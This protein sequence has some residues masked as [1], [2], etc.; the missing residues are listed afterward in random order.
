MKDKQRE[1]EE[2]SLTNSEIRKNAHSVLFQNGNILKLIGGVLICILTLIL[3]LIAGRAVIYGFTG[4]FYY[5]YNDSL[6]YIQTTLFCT[7]LYYCVELLTICFVTVPTWTALNRL[8]ADIVSGKNVTAADFC[9]IFL[10]DGNYMRFVASGI[11]S[12]LKTVA[13]LIVLICGGNLS[14]TLI[15]V[16]YT[17]LEGNAAGAQI[18]VTVIMTILTIVSACAVMLVLT[19]FFAI[20]YYVSNGKTVRQAHKLS[21]M[22]TDGNKIRIM[23]YMLGFS[24]WIALSVLT[25][26]TL[27]VLYTLPLMALS[28]QIFC[29]NLANIK[30][31]K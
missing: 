25:V 7:L 1:E 13:V 3:P 11:L 30:E 22:L 27:F 8:A 4:E 23:S 26:G 19:P 18:S 2:N 16:I 20:P 6:Q 14:Y 5:S 28:Y 29:G 31:A 24:G 12:L 9:R 21:F 15:E 10:G 17:V